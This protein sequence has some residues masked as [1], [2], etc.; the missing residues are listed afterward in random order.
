M[1]EIAFESPLFF[2]E[3]GDLHFGNSSGAGKV[4]TARKVLVELFG[5]QRSRG[6]TFANLGEMENMGSDIHLHHVCHGFYLRKFLMVLRCQFGIQ[7]DVFIAKRCVVAQVMQTWRA[8]QLIPIQITHRAVNLPG[9]WGLAEALHEHFV[10]FAG[11]SYEHV[12]H[13][14]APENR[15][16]FAQLPHFFGCKL[17][18]ACSRSHGDHHEFVFTG[19][20]F[21]AIPFQ[22]RHEIQQHRGIVVHAHPSIDKCTFLSTWVKS[23]NG[24]REK[25][26]GGTAC[27]DHTPKWQV[28]V[29]CI[30]T[31][32]WIVVHGPNAEGVYPLRHDTQSGRETG[33]PEGEFAAGRLVGV[34]FLKDRFDHG[35]LVPIEKVLPQQP[36]NLPEFCGM[37][38]DLITHFFIFGQNVLSIHA[39]GQRSRD[40]RAR[41]RA[42][43]QVKI[44]P[45]EQIGVVVPFAKV[46][47]ELNEE[48]EGNGSA[49]SAAIEG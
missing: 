11:V 46:A 28:L 18:I 2:A 30:V 47:F 10:V 40:D 32:F 44:V 39:D 1:P 4:K 26:R 31:P 21:E 6:S 38:E 34:E 41:T 20:P 49:N 24:R 22:R 45:Q 37:F 3:S 14:A 15:I 48:S 27:T 16:F 33:V 12:R 29:V 8:C 13:G 17:H 19:R 35:G 23:E 5:T 25:S 9:G 42:T 43:N 7:R 36:Q